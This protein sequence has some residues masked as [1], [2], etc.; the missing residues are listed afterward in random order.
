VFIVSQDSPVDR[1][2]EEDIVRIYSGEVTDWGAIG[3]P[4]NGSIIA[5]QRPKNSGSQT[6]LENI[7]VIRRLWMRLAMLC[8]KTA[9]HLC[10]KTYATDHI[11]LFPRFT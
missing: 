4:E 5:Y 11:R 6:A 7:M 3:Y 9:R 8:M 1:L 2:S 10:L